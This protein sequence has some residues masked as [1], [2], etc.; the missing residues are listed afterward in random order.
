MIRLADK[1]IKTIL[2]KSSA[3][4]FYSVFLFKKEK[5]EREDQNHPVWGSH[6]TCC[7]SSI[8]LRSSKPKYQSRTQK[9]SKKFIW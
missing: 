3:F 1:L 7:D 5:A 6:G 8:W 2:K 4:S 9:R